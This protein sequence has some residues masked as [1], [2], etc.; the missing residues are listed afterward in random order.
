MRTPGFVV[1]QG[2]TH[3][4]T[5]PERHPVLFC[6]RRGPTENTS[7]PPR[8]NQLHNCL[9]LTTKKT[10]DN[11]HVRQ[12]T[13][14]CWKGGLGERELPQI[15][16][17]NIDESRSSSINTVKWT[18]DRI[19]HRS[20][21]VDSSVEVELTGW[22]GKPMRRSGSGRGIQYQQLAA[23]HMRVKPR[24][25]NYRPLVPTRREN[26]VDVRST[27][28]RLPT[29]ITHGVPRRSRDLFQD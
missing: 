26:K 2:V 4:V 18:H 13:L 3:H 27:R 17:G 29:D 6:S 8:K 10:D 15:V 21:E 28:Y 25:D 12:H 24:L 9:S 20:S 14:S 11:T 5:K 16:G 23:V 22:C 7:I 19:D 1:R